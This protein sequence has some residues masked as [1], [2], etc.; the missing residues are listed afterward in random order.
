LPVLEAMGCGCPVIA[1]NTSSLPEVAGN[2]ALL[3]DPRQSDQLMREL[4]R[5]LESPSLQATL[6]TRGLARA[7]TFTW[8]RTA[9]ET[10]AVYERTIES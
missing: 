1:S 3:M 6:R 2:A 9:R 4:T 10:V 5:V 8:D 7:N